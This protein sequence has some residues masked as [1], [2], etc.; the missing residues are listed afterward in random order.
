MCTDPRRLT[1]FD[2]LKEKRVSS[3]QT[4]QKISFVRYNSSM[5]LLATGGRK[6]QVW[7]LQRP[8]EPVIVIQEQSD[9][10]VN[11]MEMDGPILAVSH[12]G[13]KARVWDIRSGARIFTLGGHKNLVH[14][15]TMNETYFA[16]GSKDCTVLLWVRH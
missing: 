9:G 4:G 7:D 2:Y 5:S 12:K 10:V 8:S 3:I 11:C 1:T 13:R 15:L 16:T 14:C 6:A